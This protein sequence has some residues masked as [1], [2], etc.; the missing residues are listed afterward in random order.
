MFDF[1]IQ[2]KSHHKFL[3]YDASGK[4]DRRAYRRCDS[5]VYRSNDGKWGNKDVIQERK[6]VSGGASR[7]S[8]HNCGNSANRDHNHQLLVLEC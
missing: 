6:Q 1:R 7:H 5:R 4:G 8:R 3:A 2:S